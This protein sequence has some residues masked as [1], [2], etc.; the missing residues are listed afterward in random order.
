[1]KKTLG[2]VVLAIIATISVA[3]AA[4]IIGSSLTKLW[5]V[6]MKGELYLGGDATLKVEAT[7]VMFK[8][9]RVVGRQVNSVSGIAGPFLPLSS[10]YS[11][12]VTAGSRAGSI[13][14][15]EGIV[16]VSGNAD[17]VGSFVRLV[18]DTRSDTVLFSLGTIAVNASLRNASV[19]VFPPLQ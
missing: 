16:S 4:P 15:L 8:D 10:Q 17:L 13:I 5:T 19:H 9:G 6:Q 14:T 2:L 18:G 11:A 3:Y 12:S 1:M 7:A